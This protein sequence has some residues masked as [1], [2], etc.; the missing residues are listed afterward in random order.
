MLKGIRPLERK[1][2]VKDGLSYSLQ[3][4]TILYKPAIFEPK[5]WRAL[6]ISG[7]ARTLVLL[8]N[9]ITNLTWGVIRICTN[10]LN[11]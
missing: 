1:G 3:P 9:S 6:L 2:S 7:E 4:K 8:G 10:Q 5:S 11:K